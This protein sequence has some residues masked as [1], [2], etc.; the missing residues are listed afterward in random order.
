MTEKRC[1][2][3]SGQCMIRYRVLAIACF[4]ASDQMPKHLD[5][6]TASLSVHCEPHTSDIRSLKTQSTHTV[7]ARQ[8]REGMPARQLEAHVT[9]E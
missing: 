8:G 7:H 2:Q 5:V 3:L 9:I 4:S 1:C 6:R